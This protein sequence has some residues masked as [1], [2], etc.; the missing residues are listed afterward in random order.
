MNQ[1]QFAVFLGV[2]DLRALKRGT[3]RPTALV[4]LTLTGSWEEVKKFSGEVAREFGPSPDGLAYFVT[5]ENVKVVLEDLTEFDE[6]DK[7]LQEG[8][9]R[10]RG[11]A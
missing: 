6:W 5:G 1:P 4:P 11:A 9:T 3:R 8:T 2:W 10:D 7:V